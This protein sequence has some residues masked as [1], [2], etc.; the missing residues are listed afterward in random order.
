M[1]SPLVP[2][3]RLAMPT[4]IEVDNEGYQIVHR[5]SRTFPIPKKKAHI[6]NRK[7]D[8]TDDDSRLPPVSQS[9]DT[10]PAHEAQPS[11][12]PTASVALAG[13]SQGGGIS[14]PFDQG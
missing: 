5:K 7:V 11:S 12:F 10:L 1:I 14:I 3:K 2:P 13:S 9:R 6:D 8:D 4:P